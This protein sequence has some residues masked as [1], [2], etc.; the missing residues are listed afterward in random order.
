MKEK[1]NTLIFSNIR[2]NKFKYIVILLVLL[3]GLI[4]GSFYATKS[5]IR[6][7][8]ITLTIAT[9]KSNLLFTDVFIKNLR[10]FLFIWIS[11]AHI[12]L[13]PINYVE[14]F[15]KGFGIGYTVAYF[16]LLYKINGFVI[17]FLSLVVQNMLALPT[18]LIF[19][20]FQLNISINK[21]RFNKSKYSVTKHNFYFVLCTIFIVTLCST[22]DV[23]I[24][25]DIV[26]F[27]CEK[28]L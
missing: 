3:S 13:V 25:P 5:Y 9:I 27:F 23:Y 24:V 6:T 2:T 22:A 20:V 16:S 28:W 17:S 8:N 11:S 10:P 1:F 15:S 26:T 21:H 12:C 18:L 4:T 14:V 7:P 19:S